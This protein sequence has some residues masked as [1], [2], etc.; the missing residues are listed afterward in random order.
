MSSGAVRACGWSAEGGLNQAL[1]MRGRFDMT[2]RRFALWRGPSPTRCVRTWEI[3]SK[4][5]WT[6][7]GTVTEDGIRVRQ[8]AGPERTALLRRVAFFKLQQNTLSIVS[9]R[10]RRKSAR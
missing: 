8:G 7:D 3:A 2:S 4:L 6:L 9:L 1:R 5:D 10:C